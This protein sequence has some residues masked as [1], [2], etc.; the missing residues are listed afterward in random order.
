RPL[1]T[2]ARSFGKDSE[3]RALMA[4]LYGTSKPNRAGNP[5][6][7]P[8]SARKRTGRAQPRSD[9]SL[10]RSGGDARAF[11]ADVHLP[12]ALAGV[13]PGLSGGRGFGQAAHGCAASFSNPRFAVCR[14]RRGARAGLGRRALFGG[15][16]GR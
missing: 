1:R 5:E 3:T 16:A 14:D 4:T 11:H 7:A 2:R 6:T 9:R 12:A 8:E 10:G 15:R 13:L